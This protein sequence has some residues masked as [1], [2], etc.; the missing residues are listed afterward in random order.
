M[1]K[2]SAEKLSAFEAGQMG[3]VRSSHSILIPLSPHILSSSSPPL[4]TTG[5]FCWCGG[6]SS[7]RSS[8]LFTLFFLTKCL[9]SSHRGMVTGLMCV[10]A[11]SCF[12][13]ALNLTSIAHS[14]TGITTP[15]A[16]HE[17]DAVPAEERGGG[18]KKE[19]CRNRGC[20]GNLTLACHL[21][22]GWIGACET[23]IWPC[24]PSIHLSNEY[25]RDTASCYGQALYTHSNTR[26]CFPYHLFDCSKLSSHPSHYNCD[27]APPLPYAEPTSTHTNTRLFSFLRVSGVRGFSQALRRARL[28]IQDVLESRSFRR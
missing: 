28:H 17:K 21:A 2:I 5:T 9:L 4:P 14:Y 15:F 27:H 25:L 26:S 1:A 3:V 11:H 8:Q 10:C 24:C 13:Q 18:A 23:C 16:G 22:V 20:K 12:S 7:T 6:A 19:D